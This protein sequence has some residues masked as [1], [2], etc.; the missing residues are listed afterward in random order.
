[1]EMLRQIRYL[2]A[3]LF[4]PAFTHGQ[5]RNGYTQTNLISDGSVHARQTD[6]N[7]I[8]PWG[9]AIGQQTPFWINSA[10]SGLSEVY[11]SGG[12][13]QFVVNIPAA[14]GST[15][16]GTPT[17]IA[18]NSSTTDFVLNQGSPALFIFDALDG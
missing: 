5:N 7:L 16:T 18:F 2:A 8:N 13:K 3:L 6:P 15:N 17:G 10:G 12:N 1:M 14:G 9:V 11:D 4:L